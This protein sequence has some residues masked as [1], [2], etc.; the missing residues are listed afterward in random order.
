MMIWWWALPGMLA[1]TMGVVFY[2]LFARRGWDPLPRGWEEDPQAIREGRRELVLRQIKELEYETGTS[3]QDRRAVQADLEQEFRDLESVPTVLAEAS[4]PATP[5]TDTGSGRNLDRAI[6]VALIMLVALVGGGVYLLKG[7]PK[8]PAATT[9][10]DAADMVAKIDQMAAR[11]E[12]EPDNLTGWLQ[13][14]RS[15]AVTGQLDKAARTYTRILKTRPDQIEAQ[16]GLGELQ[17]RSNDPE[18]V[19]LGVRLFRR[20]LLKDP[21]HP[22]ALWYLGAASYRAGNREESLT[23]WRRL[24]ANLPEAD[25][26]REMVQEAMAEAERM[27]SPLP[28]RP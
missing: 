3:E 18:Q 10:M 27:P 7:V 4:P 9:T 12:N 19:T 20:I 2:P 1:L 16:V 15:Y 24:L 8:P 21:N 14:G 22:E 17:I 11:L 28:Q 13:L 6:G 23:H 25:P 5:P 26:S